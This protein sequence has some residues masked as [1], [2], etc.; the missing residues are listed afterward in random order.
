MNESQSLLHVKD[1]HVSH[2]NVAVLFDVSLQLREGEVV[3]LV[4][5][6]G[7]GKTTLFRSIAGFLPKRRGEVLFRGVSI[8]GRAPY[9]IAQGGIKYIHQDKQVFSD[10]TVRENLELSSYATSD[11]DWKPLFAYFPT[12]EKLLDRKSGHL[13][14]GERQMLLISMA[15]LGKPAL[16]LLDEPTE[17]LAPHV[18]T[19]LATIFSEVRQKTTLFIIEQNLPLVSSIGDRV[20]CLKEG[21]I[22]ADISDRA[23]IA[24]ASFERY[25]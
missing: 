19:H 3:F 12:L 6:N 22:A 5:R 11:R 23:D 4:G 1:L 14:G 16:L 13:S 2:G 8:A 9:S 21:R 24:T 20:Y 25:L 17:G 18:V 7:A 10:L 15:L